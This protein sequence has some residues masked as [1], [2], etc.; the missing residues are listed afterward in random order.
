MLV[1]AICEFNQYEI[2]NVTVFYSLF[3][4]KLEEDVGDKCVFLQ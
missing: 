1:H 4:R 3:I 2:K